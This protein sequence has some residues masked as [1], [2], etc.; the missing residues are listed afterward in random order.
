MVA[1]VAK[2]H[3]VSVCSVTL[4]KD[5]SSGA[6]VC[7]NLPKHQLLSLSNLCQAVSG[8]GA[9][10]RQKKGAL[11]TQVAQLEVREVHLEDSWSLIDHQEESW[12]LVDHQEESWEIVEIDANN[13]FG[14]LS[15]SLCNI[16]LEMT[17]LPL[18]LASCGH[19][20][21]HQCWSRYLVVASICYLVASVSSAD[22]TLP[23]RCPE[24][25]CSKSVDLVTA[26]FILTRRQSSFPTWQ[27][28]FELS[29]KAL[30]LYI[31]HRCHRPSYLDSQTHC[32]CRE[33]RCLA[34]GQR[35][36]WPASC[37]DYALSLQLA[38]RGG[39]TTTSTSSPALQRLKPWW[40][41]PWQAF[42]GAADSSSLATCWR[43]LSVR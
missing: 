37:K 29:V 23:L 38:T 15:S 13:K 11:I 42:T 31:C 14:P 39:A 17:H 36:H 6:R 2:R 5:S 19:D 24:S 35:D 12:S 8:V 28:L 41:R 1:E 4:I 7:L 26:A 18:A 32:P 3:Q 27:P 40:G 25:C 20:F 33:L 30:P 34:C 9:S 10:F 43:L 16:C 22:A 21:C